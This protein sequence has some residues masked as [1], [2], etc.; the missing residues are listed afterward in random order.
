[1]ALWGVALSAGVG[2]AQG[3]GPSTA[4]GSV[5]GLVRTG[6]PDQYRPVREAAVLIAALKLATRTDSLGRY[7]LAEVPAGT[8]TLEIRALGFAPATFTVTVK[9]IKEKPPSL[10]SEHQCI[11]RDVAVNRVS[12]LP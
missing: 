12:H 7:L 1:M 6:L 2:L 10:S 9:E 4:A 8:H 11:S 3:A 5:S